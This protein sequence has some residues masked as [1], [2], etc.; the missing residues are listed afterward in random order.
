MTCKSSEGLYHLKKKSRRQIN[1]A[2]DK[3]S[4]QEVT[5][6]KEKRKDVV[7]WHVT[8]LKHFAIFNSG[9]IHYVFTRL[10]SI[11]VN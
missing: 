11:E 1:V 7:G 4:N 8:D 5:P 10:T 3:G 9:E 6:P 2:H